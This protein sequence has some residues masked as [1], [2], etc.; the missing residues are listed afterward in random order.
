MAAMTQSRDNHTSIRRSLR[1]TLERPKSR[2]IGVEHFEKQ[3]KVVHRICFKTS[4]EEE[5]GKIEIF[6]GKVI[7][8]KQQRPQNCSIALL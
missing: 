3:P 5:Q 7:N 4:E 6:G 1:R 8:D 2:R